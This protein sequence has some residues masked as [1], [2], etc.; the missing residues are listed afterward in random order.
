MNLLKKIFQ[1][2]LNPI[3]ADLSVV[4]VDMHSHLLPGID[5]G[6][7][8]M[9]TTI[10]LLERLV[11]L[12]FKKAITTPHIMVDLYGNTPELI[13]EKEKKVREE[14]AK[15]QI[16]IEFEAAAEY[17]IDEGFESI[18]ANDKLLTF[19]NNFLL[20]ELPYSGEPRNLGKILFDLQTKGYKVVLAHPER[21]SYWHNNYDKY[22]NLKDTGVFFQLNVNSVTRF[23]STD[24]RKV[25]SWLVKQQMIDF[26]GTDL[27][28]KAYLS[29]LEKATKNPVLIDLLNSGRLKNH[30]LLEPTAKI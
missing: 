5:D 17:L 8:D 19:G 1:G 14:I 2:N 16:N 4:G 7:P 12:G 30:E 15:N 28:N 24:T 27:H 21:Y 18:L 6:S 13:K 23:H 20:V 22:E 11:G 29:V 3:T 26:L 10:F 25:A 9:E